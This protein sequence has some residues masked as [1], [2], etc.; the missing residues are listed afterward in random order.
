MHFIKVRCFALLSISLGLGAV[1]ACAFL[2]HPVGS[3]LS[4]APYH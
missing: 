3:A 2:L 1:P 4:V